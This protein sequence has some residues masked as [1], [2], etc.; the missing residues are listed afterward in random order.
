MVNRPRI[1]LLLFVAG[2]PGSGEEPG[3][4]LVGFL[5]GS[6]RQRAGGTRPVVAAPPPGATGGEE[7][8]HLPPQT[9][10]HVNLVV[11]VAHRE[12]RTVTIVDVNRAGVNRDLVERWV[13]PNDVLPILVRTDGARL[14][15]TEK[16]VPH[17]LRRFVG[18]R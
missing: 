15:G 13:G 8:W 7:P 17:V 6:I 9:I 3:W 2:E 14:E 16:F 5:D 11:E 10:K 1:D 12:G 4:K 18:Q